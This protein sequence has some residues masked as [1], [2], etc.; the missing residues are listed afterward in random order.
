[1]VQAAEAIKGIYIQVGPYQVLRILLRF[2]SHNQRLL[3]LEELPKEADDVDIYL[4]KQ[5]TYPKRN[6]DA[7]KESLSKIVQIN[8][9]FAESEHLGSTNNSKKRKI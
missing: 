3:H 6:I 8:G 5:A 2:W 1:M 7:D 4:D 9:I